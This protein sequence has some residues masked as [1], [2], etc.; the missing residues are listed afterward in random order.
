LDL[1]IYSYPKIDLINNFDRK[2]L[3]QILGGTHTFDNW[4]NIH[5]G[6]QTFDPVKQP[7]VIR[8][9]LQSLEIPVHAYYGDIEL[10]KSLL[11]DHDLAA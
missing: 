9:F 6:N 1:H 11:K 4:E 3:N 7:K 5:F 2:L 8:K 10:Y